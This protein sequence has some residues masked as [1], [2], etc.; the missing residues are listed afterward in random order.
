MF[1]RKTGFRPVQHKLPIFNY[2]PK[3][4]RT[5]FDKINELINITNEILNM[6]TELIIAEIEDDKE[7]YELVLEE[8][9]ELIVTE[10]KIYMKLL[11]NKPD[12]ETLIKRISRIIDLLYKKICL[13]N[14]I[15][16]LDRISIYLRNKDYTNPFKSMLKT[17]YLATN[18]NNQIIANQYNYDHKKSLI[19][20]I[21][22]AL[23]ECPHQI[24]AELINLKYRNI[25]IAKTFELFLLRPFE[26]KTEISGRENA[27]L[28][29]HDKTT[30]DKIY[31][32]YSLE[33]ITILMDEIKQKIFFTMIDQGSSYTLLDKYEDTI[34][35][36]SYLSMLSKEEIKL[37]QQIIFKI[38]PT[39]GILREFYDLLEKYQEKTSSKK[40]EPN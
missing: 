3:N 26:E 1:D 32:N 2:Q 9:K 22:H 23:E 20:F 37:I 35:L 18:Q 5:I 15:S 17:P 14:K 29:G 21:N 13:E 7:Y 8:L 16:I 38:K 33:V 34:L 31:F 25:F 27:V 24:Q 4:D 12:I 36:E 11:E 30:V 19:K 6:Y 39:R 10:N 28:F 40:L